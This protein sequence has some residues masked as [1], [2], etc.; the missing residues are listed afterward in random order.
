MT[1]LSSV[2]ADTRSYLQSGRQPEINK[3]NG[4]INDSVTSLTATYALKGI[5]PDSTLAINLEEIHVWTVDEGAKQADGLERGVNGTTA[6]THS[7]GDLIYVNPLYSNYRVLQAI[8]RT[9]DDLNSKGLFQTAAVELTG[10]TSV[11]GY[12]LA[13]SNLIEVTEVFTADTS[14]S[15]KSWLPVANWRVD[16]NAETDDFAS[17]VALQVYSP[18]F[19]GTQLRVIYRQKLSSS[20]SGLSDN[21]ETTTGIDSGALDILAM[22]AAIDLTAGKEIDRSELD[23]QRNTRRSADVPSGAW[24][25]APRNLHARYRDRV[26]SERRRLERL[27][28]RRMRVKS[29]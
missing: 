26:A 15:T 3:L 21:V 24:T 18:I 17:G 20:L 7:D 28:P 5:K 23:S 13:P 2:I 11:T 10:N 22:G 12:N 6:A 27:Y 14:S 9:V 29:F 19:N 25:A 8:N 4:G 1:A 16:N